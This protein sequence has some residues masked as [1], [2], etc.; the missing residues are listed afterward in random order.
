MAKELSMLKIIGSIIIIVIA[1]ASIMGCG[2]LCENKAV[3]EI[4]LPNSGFKV[5]GFLRNCGATTD[6]GAHVSIIKNN[7]TLANEAGNI[8][9]G[10]HLYD[11]DISLRNGD[12][13][14]VS[15][16]HGREVIYKAEQQF[17]NFKIEYKKK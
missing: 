5:V 12:T 1:A 6:Y 15:Y 7:Q 4:S 10:D 16:Q 3:K 13:I 9:I 17:R 11:I 2:D 14:I 8:F